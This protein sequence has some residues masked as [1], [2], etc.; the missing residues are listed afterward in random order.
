MS[1]SERGR[2]ESL[3]AAGKPTEALM[4]LQDAVRAEPANPKLRTFLFQLLSVL[5]QWERAKTQLDVVAEMDSAAVVMRQMYAEALQCE[6]LRAN[7]FAGAKAPM[8]FG[9][10]DQWLAMLIEALLM[11]AKGDAAAA[12]KLRASALEL[13]PASGGTI[14]GERFD[15]IA[16]AD[17]R[18]GPV[19]E[20]VINN[21]YY[22]LP[23]KNLIGVDIEAP[24]DLRDQIWLPA[25]LTFVNGGEALALLP[26]RYAGTESSPDELAR[27]ARRT[28]F[29][30]RYPGVFCG[31]GQRILVTDAAEFSLL[32]I[33]SIQF[34]EQAAPADGDAPDEAE[35]APAN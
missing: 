21:R 16:D 17:S 15:W 20:A 33:R 19:L 7:V 6:V 26:V 24:T 27:L 1:A 3:L 9:Y 14:N 12:S 29:D 4:A 28:S 2:A 5:G 32:D 34:D 23:F 35:S 18:I 8:V 30:E 31:V 13:A 10:P 22:W 25:K 11:E